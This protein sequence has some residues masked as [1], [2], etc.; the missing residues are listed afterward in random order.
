MTITAQIAE[1][2][3]QDRYLLKSQQYEQKVQ[4]LSGAGQ[5]RV[6]SRESPE[7]LL[8][9]ERSRLGEALESQG[10]VR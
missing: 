10:P 2:L 8:L 6:S 9:D 5:L 7:A 3:V 4:L 1:V